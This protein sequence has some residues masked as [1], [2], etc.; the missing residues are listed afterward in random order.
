[1][2]LRGLMY[3]LHRPKMGPGDA[4]NNVCQVGIRAFLQGCN[5]PFMNGFFFRN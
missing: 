2:A 1:M 4:W 3:M 5:F